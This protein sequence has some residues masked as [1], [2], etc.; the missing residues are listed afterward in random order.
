MSLES[1]G[2]LDKLTYFFFA[3]IGNKY[4]SARIKYAVNDYSSQESIC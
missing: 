4:Y 2:L 3:R 1:D